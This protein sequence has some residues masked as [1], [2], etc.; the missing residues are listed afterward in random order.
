MWF[1][2]DICHDTWI[3]HNEARETN[4]PHVAL[5]PQRSQH[6]TSFSWSRG[7]MVIIVYPRCLQSV[8]TQ[9]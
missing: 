1:R 5:S 2:V 8:H 4:R 9:L 7:K 3:R 6:F